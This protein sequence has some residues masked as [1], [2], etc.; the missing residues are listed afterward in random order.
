MSSP[1]PP[2]VDIRGSSQ[3]PRRLRNLDVRG[4]NTID[5]GSV[6]HDD[7]DASDIP[8]AIAADAWS[9]PLPVQ[10]YDA[11]LLYVDFTEGAGSVTL[12]IHTQGAWEKRGTYYDRAVS[13]GVSTGDSVT[14]PAD[15]H[16]E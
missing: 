16:P 11:V 2:R 7:Y 6:V 9:D 3:T 15:S 12:T 4:L 1:V 5:I 13:F 14:I 10:G 8:A